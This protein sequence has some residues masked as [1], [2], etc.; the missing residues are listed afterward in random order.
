MKVSREKEIH[1]NVRIGKS[2]GDFEG[3][4]EKIRPRGLKMR[5][6]ANEIYEII[7]PPSCFTRICGLRVKRKHI[8]PK[9]TFYEN[10]CCMESA[11]RQILC[12][13]LQGVSKE[14]SFSQVS[15][16]R[17]NKVFFSF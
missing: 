3:D 16:I 7:G 5:E 6:R 2:G 1:S 14:C 15:N 10:T 9:G 17:W 12:L 4:V 8:A 11:S 13:Q